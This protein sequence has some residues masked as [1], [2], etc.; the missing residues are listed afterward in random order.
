MQIENVK[1]ST[2]SSK[3][4]F[5]TLRE[6]PQ[7]KENPYANRDDLIKPLPPEGKLVHTTIF[8]APKHW[9][10]GLAYDLKSLKKGFNGTAND[11]ELGKLNSIGMV[12]GGTALAT[13]L[14]TRRVTNSSKAMEFVGIGSFLASMALWPVV[15]IQ[16]PTQIIHGFNVRQHYKD[17]MDREKLFFNDPQYIPWDLYDDKQI[18]KIGDYMGVPR[19]MNNRR[20]YVQDKMQKIA[21]QDNTLWMLSAGFAVPIMSAL[22]CNQAEQPVKNLC[23]YIQ[24]IQ[25]KKILNKALNT[26]Y[27]AENSD[28]YKRLDSF[29]ELNKGK[30]LS[31]DMVNQLCEIIGYEENAMVN[32]KLQA[33]LRKALTSEDTIIYPENLKKMHA[34]LAEGIQKFVE[35][36]EGAKAL[37]PS[38]EEFG[39]WVTE[40]DFVNKELP[41]TVELN[42]FIL[43]KLDA[44]RVAF[45]EGLP[46]EKII[47][48]EDVSGALNNIS[49]KKSAIRRIELTN[50]SLTLDPPTQKMLRILVKELVT[51][52]HK[53]DIVKDYI[54]KELSAAP[55][56]HLANISNKMTEDIFSAL[57]IPWKKM[58][59][60]R[61]NR[62]LMI[63]VIR[64]SMDRI[65]SNK[66]EFGKV[67]RKLVDIAKRLDQFD[68]LT[69][70]EGDKTFLEQTMKKVFGP[71]AEKL[72]KLGFANT[73]NAL[74]GNQANSE[75]STLR[76]FANNRVLSLKSTIYRLISSLDMHRRI[77]TMTNIGADLLSEDVAREIKEEIV[78]LSKRTMVHAH[79]SD[80]ATKFHFNG[81]TEP[82]Y[83]DTSDIEIKRGRV[84]NSYYKAGT[85]DYKDVSRDIELYRGTMELM[86]D[87]PLHPD[88][89]RILGK[90]FGETIDNYRNNCFSIF[91]DEYYFIKPESF[92]SEI[93]EEM[94]SETNIRRPN[95]AKA[96]FNKKP[97]KLKFLM[98]GV[99]MDDMALR[100]S[101]QKHNARAWMKLFGGLGLG[102]FGATVAAQFFF[103][104]MP[105]PKEQVKS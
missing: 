94:C 20:D 47:D 53:G 1:N 56:T 27:D 64:E 93:P 76:A 59:K 73:A 78:E 99:S 61:G 101:S 88:S 32:T 10:N 28:M 8:N 55:E 26:K 35:N 92:L 98:T 79:R 41:N 46:E 33:E 48:F 5:P 19:N 103:G 104:K 81:N 96:N 14:A 89:Q 86:Y 38:L 87:T 100:Y 72:E 15:A 45:N 12:T 4:F 34:T 11:H 82:D 75:K 85:K 91:G 21:T 90:N 68:N 25:N 49:K 2:Y 69:S 43:K 44:R 50:V 7:K 17:S 39:Q 102:I 83:S 22:I 60:A 67:M 31:N 23:G 16:I 13:Y 77:A 42:K 84:V 95:Y 29:L 40:G 36:E 71:S 57:D 97:N 105:Q 70:A 62:D 58:D 80:F 54:Y 24:N 37:T 51:V 66:A 65:A 63:P 30:K 52:G 18:N 9:A 74:A 6:Q 3:G